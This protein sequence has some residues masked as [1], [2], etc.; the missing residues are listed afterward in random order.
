M[1]LSPRVLAGL[2]VVLPALALAQR[3]KDTAVPRPENA[4]VGSVPAVNAQA[5]LEFLQATARFGM[6]EAEFGKLAGTKSTSA[7]VRMFA[8]RMVTESGQL[9]EALKW[10][11]QGKD[12]ALPYMLDSASQNV[13]DDLRRKDAYPFDRQ[14]S[15]QM[16]VTHAEAV[17][18][19]EKALR[20]THSATLR[21]FA[22]KM[23]PMLR[24]QLADAKALR[25]EV[26]KEN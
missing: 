8:G 10:A 17:A 14:Y 1:R 16:K 18:R 5:D 26:R 20:T 11:T 21:S 3:S 6:A 9:A 25:E 22:D 15:K 23:L 2:C 12:L 7:A 24:A 4:A 13:L 19:F